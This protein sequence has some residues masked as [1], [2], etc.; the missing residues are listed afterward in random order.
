[1][2][3]AH[4]P[5]MPGIFSP[6]P[7]SKETAGKRSRYASR[8]VRHARAVMHVGIT[9]PRWRGNVLGIPGACATR[10]FTYLTRGPW[11]V[12]TRMKQQLRPMVPVM[13]TFIG[14]RNVCQ[15]EVVSRE[16]CD[17]IIH[18]NAINKA[19]S[20]CVYCMSCNSYLYTR[21]HFL[22][23]ENQKLK[24]WIIRVMRLKYSVR[25]GSITFLMMLLSC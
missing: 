4:A 8:H 6:P 14:R 5:G 19:D 10:S 17:L 23:I 2:R 7:T 13:Q 24:Q 25:H 21:S 3:V 22:H 20:R 12:T 18:F 9:N 15:A 16:S 11:T 1:M